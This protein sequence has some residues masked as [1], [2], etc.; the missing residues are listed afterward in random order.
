MNLSEL[1]ASAC[2]IDPD[3][4]DFVLAETAAD[5]AAEQVAEITVLAEGGEYAARERAFDPLAVALA[6]GLMA[7]RH[8]SDDVHQLHDL[9]S[10]LVVAEARLA[11]AEA[12]Q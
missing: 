5:L 8:H 4:I 12:D 11:V 7:A 9:Y 6:D 2:V 3:L 10:P 1:M